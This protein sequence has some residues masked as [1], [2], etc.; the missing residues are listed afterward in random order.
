M[1]PGARADGVK[2]GLGTNLDAI[3]DAL[4]KMPKRNRATSPSRAQVPRLDA[5]VSEER[6]G[7]VHPKGPC[8]MDGAAKEQVLCI[9]LL[10][11]SADRRKIQQ[12]VCVCAKG[13]YNGKSAPS[14]HARTLTHTHTT[15]ERERARARERAIQKEPIEWPRTRLLI[16]LG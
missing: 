1:A 8:A 5:R 6:V 10:V 4:I 13:I 15:R 3:A 14:P 12:C 7:R 9:L 11:L 2:R 16:P